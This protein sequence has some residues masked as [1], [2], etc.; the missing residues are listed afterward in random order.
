[1]GKG[2]TMSD[3]SNPNSTSGIPGVAEVGAH[4]NDVVARSHA[5]E[6]TI[7]NAPEGDKVD[8]AIGGLKVI[9]ASPPVDREGRV[10]VDR[11]LNRMYDVV[12]IYS[13]FQDTELQFTYDILIAWVNKEYMKRIR[14]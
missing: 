1:M 2:C 9:I 8:A 3:T 7:N 13:V 12:G 14:R 11:V 6:C 5:V 10:N 4:I